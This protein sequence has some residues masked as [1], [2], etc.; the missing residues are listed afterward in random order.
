MKTQQVLRHHAFGEAGA[1]LRL[2][3][4]PI[5]EPKA[6]E[7]QVRLLVAAI[8]PSDYGRMNGRYGHLPSLPAVAGREGVGVVEAL[9]AGVKGVVCGQRVRFSDAGAWQT[10]CCLP[11]DAL[12]FVP[13]EIP[14][15]QAAMAF[16]N[17]PTAHCLLS[18]YMDL[19][20]G[21]WIVQNAGNSAVGLAV[22][23]MAKA[24]GVRTVSQVRREALVEPLKA[25]GADVVVLEG[26]GW[27]A[28]VADL[29]GQQ[30]LRLAL[31]SVG[32]ASA[33][34]QLKVL[35]AGGTQVTFGGMTGEAVRFPTRYIIFNDLRM[36]GFW[37]DAYCQK[38]QGG[39]VDAIMA[40]VFKMFTDGS[41]RLPIAGK[42]SFS[43]Y[44]EALAHHESPRLGKILLTP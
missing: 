23:Q 7:V 37:W 32:G 27:E 39:A 44:K 41:L 15:D 8:N 5:P 43:E 11:A 9:G 33:I 17:P 26:S 30:G 21:D 25:L 4:L 36:L 10:F 42:Y 28:S 35:E 2:E 16:I 40:S 14:T 22:I 18:Q 19:K 20:A 13:E 3:W 6:G 38:A 12:V 24:M 29:T 1:V 34:A 31:N